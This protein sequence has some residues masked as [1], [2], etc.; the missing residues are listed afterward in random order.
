MDE[1]QFSCQ[2]EHVPQ[3]RKNIDAC[4]AKAGEFLKMDCP[5]ASDS[6]LGPNWYATH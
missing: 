4:V 6:M 1:F 3:L 5:L 2:W